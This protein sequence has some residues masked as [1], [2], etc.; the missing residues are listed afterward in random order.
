MKKSKVAVLF[1]DIT[2]SKRNGRN[3]RESQKML[4]LAMAGSRMGAWSRDFTNDTVYWSAELEA[5]FGL[6]AG[7]F[8]GTLGGFRDYVYAEDKDVC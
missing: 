4:S 1:N 5:I 6:P 2:E 7:T 8:S 3:L